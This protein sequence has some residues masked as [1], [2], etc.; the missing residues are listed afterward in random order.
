MQTNTLL[1]NQSVAPTIGSVYWY[2]YTYVIYS[3]YS[4]VAAILKLFSLLKEK[5]CTLLEPAAPF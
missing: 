3:C 1:H 4:E 5:G 2:V